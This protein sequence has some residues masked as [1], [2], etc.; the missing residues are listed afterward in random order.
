VEKAKRTGQ[1]SVIHYVTSDS[2]LIFISC[3]YASLVAFFP[4]NSRDPLPMVV[5]GGVGGKGDGESYDEGRVT[6]ESGPLHYLGPPGT[7]SHQVALELVTGLSRGGTTSNPSLQPC[8]TIKSTLQEAKDSTT[9]TGQTSWALLPFENNSNGPVVD[10]YDMLFSLPLSSPPM[11]VRVV[12]EYQLRVSHSLM[13]TKAV[14][15][16]V[17]RRKGTGE[18]EIDWDKFDAVSSHTQVSKRAE[19][20]PS[21]HQ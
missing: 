18:V 12:R 17:S 9:S 21:C 20:Y 10:S 3:D 14:Y 16:Q 15:A 6:T 13:C 7:Y 4:L 1:S 11:S 5:N 19:I 8:Q 2:L